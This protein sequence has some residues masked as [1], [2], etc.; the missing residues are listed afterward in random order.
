MRERP[1]GI[2]QAKRLDV[3]KRDIGEQSSP[4]CGAVK[5]SIMQEYALLILCQANISFNN[6]NANP[7]RSPK[8]RKRV[9]WGDVPIA[10]MTCDKNRLSPLWQTRQA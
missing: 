8:G 1:K 5:R 4:I 3:L 10:T 9:L 2:S 6:L 7:N